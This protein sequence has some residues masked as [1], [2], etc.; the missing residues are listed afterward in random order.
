M[1]DEVDLVGNSIEAVVVVVSFVEVRDVEDKSFELGK[2]VQHCKNSSPT[3]FVEGSKATS[4]L[5][6]STSNF[7]IL[8]NNNF[9]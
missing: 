8:H 5:E 9:N 2:F 1:W 7:G 3:K 4:A 6:H